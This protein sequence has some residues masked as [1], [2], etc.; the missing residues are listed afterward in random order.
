LVSTIAVSLAWGAPAIAAPSGSAV[1]ACVE[2]YDGAQRLRRDNRLREAETA[3]VRCGQSDCA[4]ELRKDCLPWL[5]EV[6]GAIPSIVVDAVDRSGCDL[7][8]A[9]VFVDGLEVRGKLDGT[10]IALDPGAHE[11]HVEDRD[12]ARSSQRIVVS[13]GQKN[14]HVALSFAAPGVVCGRG[15]TKLGAE[16]SSPPVK[17]GVPVLSYVLGSAGLVSLGVSSIFYADG[18]STK[19]DLDD[20]CRP[21]CAADDVDSLRR[22]FLFGDAFLVVGIAALSAATLVYLLR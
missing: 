15:A 20:S 18:L 11:V 4:A 1:D 7:E 16:G 22:S 12:G 6:R 3:L 14:R 21:S 17:K 5:E 2:A 19:S 10:A 8:D 13:L 9:R